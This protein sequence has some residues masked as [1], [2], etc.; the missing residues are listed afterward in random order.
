VE[1]VG[2]AQGGPGQVAD[3]QLLQVLNGHLLVAV[4]VQHFEEGVDVLLL[5]VVVGVEDAVGVGEDGHGLAAGRSTFT[6]SMAPLRS[7]S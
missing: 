2:H 5:R 1:L 6:G 4:D 3:A 7:L